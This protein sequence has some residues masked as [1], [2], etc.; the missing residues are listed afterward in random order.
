MI[1]CFTGFERSSFNSGS[2][3]QNLQRNDYI[4]CWSV[5]LWY[6]T[7]WLRYFRPFCLVDCTLLVLQK[8]SLL[9]RYIEHGSRYWTASFWTNLFRTWC[10]IFKGSPSRMQISQPRFLTL[11]FVLYLAGYR[12]DRCIKLYI[13]LSLYL[14]T[15]LFG[16]S[17]NSHDGCCWIKS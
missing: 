7:A 5:C 11:V 6:T 10:D 16:S 4:G 13:F 12:T 3:R 8:L 1:Q 15:K 17:M 14:I 2:F 9:Y